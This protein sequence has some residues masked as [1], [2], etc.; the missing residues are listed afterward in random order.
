MEL[1]VYNNNYPLS[2][3]SALGIRWSKEHYTEAT[4]YSLADNNFSGKAIMHFLWT[5]YKLILC[6]TSS[7]RSTWA[8]LK[9][10]SCT[11]SLWPPPLASMRAVWPS[12]GDKT[13][14]IEHENRQ[15]NGV[16]TCC[17]IVIT[18]GSQNHYYPTNYSCPHRSYYRYTHTSRTMLKLKPFFQRLGKMGKRLC[19][20]CSCKH[21]GNLHIPLHCTKFIDVIIL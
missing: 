9:R 12:W 16:Y 8:P 6:L 21:S 14:S 4:L 11:T 15:L 2:L 7:C 10:S 20:H 1:P 19:T 17:K 18:W 5:S 3:G 13:G